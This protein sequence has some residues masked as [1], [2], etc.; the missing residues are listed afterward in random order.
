[1]WGGVS[2]GRSARSPRHDGRVP[3]AVYYAIDRQALSQAET[4]Q[5][6]THTLSAA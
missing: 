6:A 1:V 3:R 2:A 4:L 5:E